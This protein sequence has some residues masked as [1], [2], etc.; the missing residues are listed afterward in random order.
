MQTGRL[1]V[2]LMWKTDGRVKSGN[3]AKEWCYIDSPIIVFID[4]VSILA[5]YPV[6][7]KLVVV[8]IRCMFRELVGNR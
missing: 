5:E 4:A 3:L 6:A 2:V 7:D 8:S 1:G